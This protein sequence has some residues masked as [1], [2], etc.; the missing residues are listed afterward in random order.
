MTPR[1]KY[2]FNA[3]GFVLIFAA[4]AGVAASFPD[5]WLMAR[6]GLLAIGAGLSLEIGWAKRII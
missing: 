4:L 2:L 5:Q 6:W 3:L 1:L